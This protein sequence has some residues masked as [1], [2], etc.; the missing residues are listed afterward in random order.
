MF[1][2]RYGKVKL[3]TYTG[4]NDIIQMKVKVSRMANTNKRYEPEFKKQ[5]VRLVLE[6]GRTIASVNKEY[7]LGE[8]TVRS[9]IRQF[10]EECETNPETNETGELY[11]ENRRLRKKLEEMEKENRFLK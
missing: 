5:M 11:E 6:E 4:I 9:W 3:N 10:E 1:L 8:G 7:H 2:A